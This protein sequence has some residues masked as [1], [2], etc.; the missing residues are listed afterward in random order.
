MKNLMKVETTGGDVWV[1]IA[2]IVTIRPSPDREGGSVM[3]LHGGEILNC[4]SEAD[5]LAMDCYETYD[6]DQDAY[7]LIVT[8]ENMGD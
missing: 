6:V 7:P 2:Y 8:V 5:A 1:D 3:T 4:I